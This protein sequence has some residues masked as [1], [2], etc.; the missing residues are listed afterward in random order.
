MQTG[1][2]SVRILAW[3][4]AL[5]W[6]LVSVWMVANTISVRA[7]VR[8]PE[9]IVFPTL[10]QCIFCVAATLLALVLGYGFFR[11][12]KWGMYGTLVLGLLTNLPLAA[13]SGSLLRGA[14]LGG[15]SPAKAVG[16]LGV[17]FLALYAAT[18]IV[19]LKQRELFK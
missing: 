3:V 9:L 15:A 10:G 16:I 1:K 6:V 18:A 12:R 17:V 2:T 11:L 14:S 19:A 13:I 5:E 4:V 8:N 7:S